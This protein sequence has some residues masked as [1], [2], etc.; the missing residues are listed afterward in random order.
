[1]ITIRDLHAKQEIT[2]VKV[3]DLEHEVEQIHE[4][5]KNKSD[6]NEVK[7]IAENLIKEK[8]FI[9][10]SEFE[11]YYQQMHAETKASQIRLLKWVIGT[12][13]SAIAAISGILGVFF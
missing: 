3:S 8:D 11:Q 7:V 9:T 4:G 12:G 10:R 2:E 13:I 5:L 6:E 1:M